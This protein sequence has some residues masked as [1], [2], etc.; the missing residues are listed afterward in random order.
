MGGEN[1]LY[2]SGG[3]NPVLC[4][5][6]EGRTGGGREVHEEET[7]VYFMADSCGCTEETFP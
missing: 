3:S 6:L 7:F 1:L 5:N 2:D 4:D